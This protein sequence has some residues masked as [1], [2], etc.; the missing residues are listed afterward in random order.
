[1]RFAICVFAA[2]TVLAFAAPALAE[3]SEQDY[4][5]ASRCSAIAKSSK[6]KSPDAAAI[7]AFVEAEEKGRTITTR[8]RADM[9]ASR[10]KHEALT[11]SGAKRTALEAEL[12]GACQAF[13]LQLAGN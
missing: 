11:A 7:K 1:M 4:I 5:Q 3:V 12:S 2:T 6:F 10:A 8:R 9:A 13:K